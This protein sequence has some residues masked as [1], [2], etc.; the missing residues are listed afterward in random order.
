MQSLYIS[1]IGGYSILYT[2]TRPG[3]INNIVFSLCVLFACVLVL[4]G[5]LSACS[6]FCVALLRINFICLC[7]FRYNCLVL[8]A[9][10]LFRCYVILFQF[11]LIKSFASNSSEAILLYATFDNN[12]FQCL[13]M[14]LYG[15]RILF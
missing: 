2:I 14:N 7:S 13:L 5:V 8:L 15:S 1:Y 4:L 10:F 9:S 12:L 3:K 6:R 11:F